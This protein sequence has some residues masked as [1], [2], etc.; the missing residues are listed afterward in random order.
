VWF[1]RRLAYWAAHRA[2]SDCS[3]VVIVVG[4]GSVIG[5]V[6]FVAVAD[7]W[8][9]CPCDCASATMADSNG[10]RSNSAEIGP[11]KKNIEK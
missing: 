5:M 7:S 10:A 6:E 3:A 11:T 1:P 9:D 4:F 2:T 8:W